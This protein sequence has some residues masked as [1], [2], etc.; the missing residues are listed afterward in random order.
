MIADSHM[1]S[2]AIEAPVKPQLPWV[3]LAWF[4]ALIVACYLP[5]LK[6]LVGQWSTDED[7]S[8]GFFVPVI[9]GFIIWQKRDDLMATKAQPTLWGML[10]VA[11]GALQMILGVLGTELFTSRTA[12]VITLIG[13]VWTLGRQ[14]VSEETGISALP[15]LPHGSHPG[16]NL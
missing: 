6:S 16:C 13:V 3:K 11:W 14:A 9:A 12:F 1:M 15:A 4:G 8:H 2:P 7:M 5:I 10:L